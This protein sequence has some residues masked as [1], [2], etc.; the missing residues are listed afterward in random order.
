VSKLHYVRVAAAASVLV[1]MAY[2]YGYENLRNCYIMRL[3]TQATQ[4]SAP[5]MEETFRTAAYGKHP[6]VLQAMVDNP[7]LT[8]VLMLQIASLADPALDEGSNEPVYFGYAHTRAGRY[9]AMCKLAWSPRLTPALAVTLAARHHGGTAGCL[10]TSPAMSDATAADLAAR[11]EA[12]S[13]PAG[14]SLVLARCSKTPVVTLQALAHTPSDRFQ[15]VRDRAA[16]TLLTLK[17]TAPP[18]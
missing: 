5:Q 1:Y 13:D 10:A 12:L 8:P 3:H 6:Y 15:T 9:S 14:L 4:M 2:A 17:A 11:P 7:N 18:P 16:T